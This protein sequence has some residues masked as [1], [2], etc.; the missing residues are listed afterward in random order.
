[1]CSTGPKPLEKVPWHFEVQGHGV[2]INVDFTGFLQNK[3]GRA[4]VICAENPRE[5]NEIHAASPLSGSV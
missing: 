3:R 2:C 4:F 1:M 5:M